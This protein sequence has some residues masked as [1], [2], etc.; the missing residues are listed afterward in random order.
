V[1]AGNQERILSE[2]ELL[3]TSN[4]TGVATAQYDTVIY[5][6]NVRGE[7]KT[8]P[9][10]KEAARPAID[11]L[12][13]TL[14]KLEASGVKIDVAGLRAEPQ[15]Q[16][17]YDYDA[18]RRQVPRGYTASYVLTFQSDSV[19][20]VSE[21]HDQLT[22]IVGVSA[23]TPNFKV[24]NLTK[25]HSKALRDARS[26]RDARFKD[27]C[28]AF[29]LNPDDYCMDSYLPSYDESESAG[30]EAFGARVAMAASGGSA[31]SPVKV[32]AGRSTVTVRLQT[33]YRRRTATD[34]LALAVGATKKPKSGSPKPAGNGTEVT[35]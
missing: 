21:V 28:A 6:C 11:A 12:E 30:P 34:A 32:K 33:S 29:G 19:D 1:D 16:P 35:S 22:E 23:D 10:A 17:A 8:G 14:K 13:A 2:K 18:N 4:V 7:G 27:E 3:T 24:K 20:R 15:V 31:R 25:L 5:T 26:K 9:K